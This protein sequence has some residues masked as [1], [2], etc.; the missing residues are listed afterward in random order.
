MHISTP[1]VKRLFC[2]VLTRGVD[3]CAR[4][5]TEIWQKHGYTRYLQHVN[6][7]VDEVFSK[8]L[9]HQVHLVRPCRA[10]DPLPLSTETDPTEAAL[11]WVYAQPLECGFGAM[12]GEQDEVMV[13]L[14]QSATH[15]AFSCLLA[16]PDWSIP[17]CSRTC[18]RVALL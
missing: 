15:A 7:H 6:H 13:A 9:I 4:N 11:L 14:A 18:R 2:A 3:V 10:V 5:L 8:A 1:R 12:D 17:W 16:V